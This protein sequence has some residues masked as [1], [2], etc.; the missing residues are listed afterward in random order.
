MG[1]GLGMGMRMDGYGCGGFWERKA[2]ECESYLHLHGS[3]GCSGNFQAS[4]SQPVHPKIKCGR[5]DD[6]NFG[7]ECWKW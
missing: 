1:M 4:S 3:T 5:Y 2:L 6:I 7:G